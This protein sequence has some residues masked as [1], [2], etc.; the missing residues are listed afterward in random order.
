MIRIIPQLKQVLVN[1]VGGYL[2]LRNAETHCWECI[3]LEHEKTCFLSD[4]HKKVIVNPNNASPLSSRSAV[5]FSN[6]MNPM[7]SCVYKII[8]CFPFPF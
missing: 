6:T 7:G 8:H 3:I 1:K 4:S 5:M 2:A